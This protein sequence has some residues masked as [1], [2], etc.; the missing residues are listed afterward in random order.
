[1]A[2]EKKSFPLKKMYFISHQTFVRGSVETLHPV[3]ELSLE[4]NCLLWGLQTVIPKS[5]QARLFTEIHE[6]HLVTTEAPV[7]PLQ[8]WIVLESVATSEIS[9][10]NIIVIYY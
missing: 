6:N 4:N 8:G 9:K 10:H 1:M 2:K 3:S 7:A 5:L